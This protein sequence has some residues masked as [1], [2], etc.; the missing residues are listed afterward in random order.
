V[1]NGSLAK[2]AVIA[3]IAVIAVVS[4]IGAILVNLANLTN[5][6]VIYSKSSFLH[7]LRKLPQNGNYHKIMAIAVKILESRYSQYK[8]KGRNDILCRNL[9]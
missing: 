3:V 4:A 1:K 2:F 6:T 8:Y 5:Y 9:P 7:K